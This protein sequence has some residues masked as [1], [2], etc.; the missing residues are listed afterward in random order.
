MGTCGAPYL[1]IHNIQGK[2]T[3][4]QDFSSIIALIVMYR[5]DVCATETRFTRAEI[6]SYAIS[7][8]YTQNEHE[9]HSIPSLI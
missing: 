1:Y 6:P 2:N 8:S 7:F 3:V 4:I 5:K 9:S